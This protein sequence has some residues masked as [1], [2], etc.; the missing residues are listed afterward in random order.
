[1][2]K[3]PALEDGP[4]YLDYNATTPVDPGASFVMFRYL[5]SHFGN[6]SSAHAYGHTTHEAVEGAREYVAELLGATPHEIIFTGGGSESD[7]LAI[8]GA[9]LPQLAAGK[10]HII[11]QVTEHPAVLKT[12]NA[13]ERLHGCRVTYLP[14][15]STGQVDPAAVEAAIENT[16]ALITIMYANNETGTIQPIPEIAAIARKHDV[17]MHSDAAQAVGKIPTLIGELGV[18]LL[19]LAGHKVYAPK[20]IGALYVREGVQLEPIIYGG[21]QEFGLRAG[22]ENVVYIVGLGLACHLAQEQLAESHIRI[23]QLRDSLH[24]QLEQYLP[25]VVHLN[26]HRTER[27][28]NTLNIS[29]DRVKGDEVLAATPEIASSTGSACHEGST[30]PSSVLLAMGLSRERALGALRLTLGRWTTEEEIEQ[31]ARLLAK[32]IDYL[33][34]KR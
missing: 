32:T 11:T 20:G 30:E 8:R 7:N 10:N 21:G 17:L 5:A 9:V 31:A 28:P 29:V 2:F 27:L 1:M 18:D 26:G 25:N 14:I 22:T 12:C 15:D 13:L 23:Q 6:P 24:Q 33:R 19:T 16:T 34:K 4:I 3:H